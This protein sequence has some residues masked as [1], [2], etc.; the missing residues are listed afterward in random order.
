M[1][2]AAIKNEGRT[3]ACLYSFRIERILTTHR[4]IMPNFEIDV[5]ELLLLAHA[6]LRNHRQDKL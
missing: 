5:S 2:M 4:Q 1:T 6:M 3:I